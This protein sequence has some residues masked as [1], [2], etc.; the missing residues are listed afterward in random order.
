MQLNVD[1][2]CNALNEMFNI[3]SIHVTTYHCCTYNIY[4]LMHMNHVIAFVLSY[5]T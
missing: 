1:D 2:C 3:I 4:E 5:A